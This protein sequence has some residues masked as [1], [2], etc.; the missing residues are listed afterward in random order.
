[1]QVK[2]QKTKYNC[3]IQGLFTKPHKIKSSLLLLVQIKTT[4]CDPAGFTG[5]V[6]H[7]A[8]QAGRD[9][10]YIVFLFRTE[11]SWIELRSILYQYVSTA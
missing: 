4:Q 11:F 2:K 6:L 5:S 1:M 9:V 3:E 8:L 10:L 7:S